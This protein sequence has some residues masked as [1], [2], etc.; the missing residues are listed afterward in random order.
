MIS[1]SSIIQPY[2]WMPW[3]ATQPIALHGDQIIKVTQGYII[4]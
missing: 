4:Q 2:Q 3:N 1:L